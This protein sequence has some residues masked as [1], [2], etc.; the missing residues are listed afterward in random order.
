MS[1]DKGSQSGVFS[2]SSNDHWEDNLANPRQWSLARKWQT[3][4]IVCNSLLFVPGLIIF[5]PD[6]A[7]Y[8]IY[9]DGN[10]YDGPR[11]AR[12]CEEIW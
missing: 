1:T 6:F 12:D 4:G 8:F 9:G 10:D 5:A 3:M 7:L 11:F 2:H